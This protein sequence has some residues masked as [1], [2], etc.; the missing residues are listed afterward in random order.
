MHRLDPLHKHEK[1]R[2][3]ISRYKFTIG[4]FIGLGTVIIV[5][6]AEHAGNVGWYAFFCALAI[7]LVFM[8]EV[9]RK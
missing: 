3:V 4:S 7:L 2:P 9:M 6:L 1:P 8:G 5:L